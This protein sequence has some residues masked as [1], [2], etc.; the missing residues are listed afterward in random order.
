VQW[1]KQLAAGGFLPP[2]AIDGD[3]PHGL[4][5]GHAG[6]APWAQIPPRTRQ[7]RARLPLGDWF[8]A[9]LKLFGIRPRKGCRCEE[10]QQA[11]NRLGERLLFLLRRLRRRSRAIAMPPGRPP[12]MHGR[13]LP[14]QLRA[15]LQKMDAG[16]FAD[17]MRTATKTPRHSHAQRS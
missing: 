6:L 9:M 15:T 16:P 17:N 12:H 11:M 2:S 14:P 1:R 3:C 5:W 4:P 13:H 10:R 8:A 7:K